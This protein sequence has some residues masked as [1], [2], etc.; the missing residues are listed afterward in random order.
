[1]EVAKIGGIV[2][3]T[4]GGVIVV[5]MIGHGGLRPIHCRSGQSGKAGSE[6][7][8]TRAASTVIDTWRS[9]NHEVCIRRSGTCDIVTALERLK[10]R[11]ILS[12]ASHIHVAVGTD[13]AHRFIGQFVKDVRAVGKIGRDMSPKRIDVSFVV[14]GDFVVRIDD[15]IHPICGCI[16]HRALHAGQLPRAISSVIPVGRRKERTR[17]VCLHLPGIEENHA[18]SIQAFR[19]HGDVIGRRL[20]L[21]LLFPNPRGA[22]PQRRIGICAEHFQVRTAVWVRNAGHGDASTIRR[23]RGGLCVRR[24]DQTDGR[25]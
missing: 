24:N 9:E 2:G 5:K 23:Q 10:T 4:V 7:S 15:D 6:V 13:A 16:V 14:V 18:H 8:H 19:P 20:L 11:R 3:D 21:P 12:I 17:C 25:A 22:R 1:M